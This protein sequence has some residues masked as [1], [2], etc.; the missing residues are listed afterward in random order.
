M[1][2][3]F[4]SSFL[5]CENLLARTSALHSLA[6]L[7]SLESRRSSPSSSFLFLTAISL[8]SSLPSF[9]PLFLLPDPPH[10]TL[11]TNALSKKKIPHLSMPPPPSLSLPHLRSSLSSVLDPISPEP[12][13]LIWSS[14]PSWP[15]SPPLRTPLPSSSSPPQS[16]RKRSPFTISILD[17]SWNPPTNAHLSLVTAPLPGF[18]GGEEEGE[19]DA[20]LLL[21]SVKNVDKTLKSGDASFE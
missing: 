6:V 11:S 9:L 17:S 18:E 14:H 21:L 16:K 4:G 8:S 13:K 2:G 3:S 20:H 19:Y 12:F 1:E 7:I 5:L 10:S 15:L